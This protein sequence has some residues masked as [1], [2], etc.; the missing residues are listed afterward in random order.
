MTNV[1]APFA[2]MIANMVPVY[3]QQ[4]LLENGIYK[5]Y[6]LK[7]LK[8]SI[9]SAIKHSGSLIPPKASKAAIEK[10]GGEID[11]FA[12]KWEHQKRA[13]EIIQGIK[14][15]NRQ[16]EAI[17]IHEHKTPIQDTLNSILSCSGNY[18]EVLNLLSNQEIVWV[19]RTENAKLKTFNRGNHNEAYSNAGIEVVENKHGFDWINKTPF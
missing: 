3:K 15:H 11:I 12:L 4:E 10:I 9:K 1:L 18:N 7:E 19:L 8:G 16:K 13:E 14:I 17:L 2:T 6:V 5:K